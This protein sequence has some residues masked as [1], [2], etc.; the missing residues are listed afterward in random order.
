MR[1]G[2]A[3]AYFR[4]RP[5]EPAPRS[6]GGNGFGAPEAFIAQKDR[7]R[8]RLKT[9]AGIALSALRL[10]ASILGRRPQR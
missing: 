9:P 3:D 8:A 7:I 5:V 2:T 4:A 6:A 1:E 10:A